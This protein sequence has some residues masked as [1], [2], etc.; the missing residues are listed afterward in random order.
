VLSAVLRWLAAHATLQPE[1]GRFSGE[2]APAVA[3]QRAQ[4]S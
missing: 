1:P 3:A 4:L 2:T